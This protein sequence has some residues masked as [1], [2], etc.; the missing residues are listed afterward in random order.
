MLADLGSYLQVLGGGESASRL[1]QVVGRIQLHMKDQ[2]PF[3]LLLV[4]WGILIFYFSVEA[5]L[6]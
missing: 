4:G 2:G 3:F 1:I 6:G 5:T